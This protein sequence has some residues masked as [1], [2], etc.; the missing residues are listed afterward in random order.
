[1]LKAVKERWCQRGRSGILRPTY[2]LKIK[3]FGS[4]VDGTCYSSL[5]N[6]RNMKIFPYGIVNGD[7]G[8]S[9]Y[10]AYVV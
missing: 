9:R 4:C 8:S 2:P 1:M 5:C 10:D 3:V 6:L 7:Q